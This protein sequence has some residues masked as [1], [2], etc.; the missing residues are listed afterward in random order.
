[1]DKEIETLLEMVKSANRKPFWQST[2]QEARSGR[3]CQLN[4]VLAK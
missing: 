1:M 4:A 2:P 3:P